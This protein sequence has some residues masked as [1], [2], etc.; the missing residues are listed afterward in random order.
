MYPPDV[1]NQQDGYNCGV[2]LLLFA[3]RLIVGLDVSGVDTTVSALQKARLVL[4]AGF[5]NEESA[6]EIALQLGWELNE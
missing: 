1:P 6:L 3:L 4:A 5:I 2:I